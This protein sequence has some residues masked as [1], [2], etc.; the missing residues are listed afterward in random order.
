M[1]RILIVE[2]SPT[3]AVALKGLLERTNFIVQIASNG[4]QA[5][6]AIHA[7][8][9]DI[10]VTDLQMP[11]MNGL[12]LVEAVSR[13]HLFLPV[14][15]MTQHGSERIAVEAL[16]KG[17]A[18]YVPKSA[19]ARDLPRAIDEVLTDASLLRRQARLR[20]CLT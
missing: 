5:M 3:Q 9:P 12:E 20:A 17:A 14:I 1:P 19:L 7:S 13:E 8:L 16:E 15:L 6:Q 18:S 11:E 2:D 10:V 4:R